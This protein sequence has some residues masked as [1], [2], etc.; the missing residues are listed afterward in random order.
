MKVR[1]LDQMVGTERDVDGGTWHSRR[2]VLADDRV[3]FSLHDTVLHAG[4]ETDMWYQNH[5]EAVYCIE[6]RGELLDKGTGDVHRLEPGTMYLLDAHDQHRVTAETDL[7]MVCVFNPPV[8]GTE[9]HDENG[10]YPLVE[11]DPD[12]IG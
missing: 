1:R 12:P 7:R 5:I 2:L 3:G 9:V 10:A 8:T 4:T 6:G 11:L